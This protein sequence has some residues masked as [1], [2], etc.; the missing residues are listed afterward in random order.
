VVDEDLWRNPDTVKIVH[1]AAGEVLYTSRAPVPYGKDGFSGEL[2][3]RRIYGIFAF[4]WRHLLAFTEHPQ[5][6][7]EREESCDSNRILDMDFRQ[8]IAPY[9]HL[10][11]YS[12][13]SPSDI[14]LVEEGLRED[15]IWPIYAPEDS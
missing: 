3:A 5:T 9:P 14:G 1:N 11:S 12:V 13:D 8:V 6:R 7:L 4:R 2:M 15:P 10:R